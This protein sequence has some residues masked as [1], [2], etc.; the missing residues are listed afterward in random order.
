[1]YRCFPDITV[2]YYHMVHLSALGHS[3]RSNFVA[4]FNR[5]APST[6][7]VKWYDEANWITDYLMNLIYKI[8]SHIQGL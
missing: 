1:M 2:E 3:A 4:D 7:G 8:C 6:V 5:C